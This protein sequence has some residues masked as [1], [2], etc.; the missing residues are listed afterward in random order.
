MANLRLEDDGYCFACGQKNTSG[1]KLNFT[2]DKE[3]SLKTEFRFNKNHQGYKDIVH[4]GMVALILDELMGNLCC[5]LGK[6]AIGAQMEVR[7]KHPTFVGSTLYFK[8]WIEKED[9]KI[10]YMK[11]E[12]RNKEGSVVALASGKGLKLQV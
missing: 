3:N 12:A 8:S 1:L 7:F 2:L 9:K 11:A 5:K 10:I 6:N 4:G